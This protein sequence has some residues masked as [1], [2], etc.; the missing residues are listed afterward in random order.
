MKKILLLLCCLCGIVVSAQKKKPVKGK[1]TVA[2]ASSKKLVLAKVGEVSAE[3]LEKKNGVVFYALSGK[4]TLFSSALQKDSGLPSDVKITPVTAGSAKLHS[5]SWNQKKKIGDPKT[6]L[7]NIT[8]SHTEIWD[9]AAKKRVFENTNS[10]NNITEIVWLDPNKTASK[11][12]EKIRREGM[13][14]SVSP[15]G[16][17]ILKNKASDSKLGYD[18]AQGK[19]T[20]KK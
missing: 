10:V 16:D 12:V 18:A 3:Q 20:A 14:C 15:Q 2:V 5:I 9:V 11:T 6:K 7:E 19:F 8:E 1:N 17:V 13:E 4:D